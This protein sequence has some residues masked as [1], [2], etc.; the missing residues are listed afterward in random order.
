MN[1]STTSH[2]I[3]DGSGPPLLERATVGGRLR[4]V[5]DEVPDRVALVEGLPT[6]ERRQWTYAELLAD[7][8]R[9]ARWLL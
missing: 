7:A 1:V 3:P 2:W 6:P 5:A 4:E 8:E 9:C